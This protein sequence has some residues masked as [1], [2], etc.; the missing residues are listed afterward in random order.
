MSTRAADRR[1][2]GD[3]LC[4]VAVASAALAALSG[5]SLFA[6]DPVKKQWESRDSLTSCGSLQLGQLETLE[7]D[8]KKE[9]ACLQRA[10]E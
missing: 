4:A 5:C 8:G 6:S 9:V 7:V 3:R 10:L 2:V 1:S